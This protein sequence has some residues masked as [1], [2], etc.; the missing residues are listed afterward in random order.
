MYTMTRACLSCV[1]EYCAVYDV[2]SFECGASLFTNESAKARVDVCQFGCGG[3]VVRVGA[4]G[5]GTCSEA[6]N[7]RVGFCKRDDVRENVLVDNPRASAYAASLWGRPCGI[8]PYRYG[9]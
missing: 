7:R 4:A 8:R 9:S 6:S 5:Y 3:G 1:L 2:F